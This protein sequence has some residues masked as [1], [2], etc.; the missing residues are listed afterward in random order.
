MQRNV[1]NID[2]VIRLVA[3]LVVILLGL[4]FGSWWGLIGLVLLATAA[5]GWCPLYVPLG[6]STCSAK[7]PR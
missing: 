5:I 4:Y 6:L 3:G 2:R 1:G 7:N